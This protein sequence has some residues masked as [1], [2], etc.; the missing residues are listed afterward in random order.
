LKQT[1]I[2][3]TEFPLTPASLQ[4]QRH[5]PQCSRRSPGPRQLQ[6]TAPARPAS[7]SHHFRPHLAQRNRDVERDS[8]PPQR[9]V[10][11]RKRPGIRQQLDLQPHL[12][13]RSSD[14][15][16]A[17]RHQQAPRRQRRRLRSSPGRRLRQSPSSPTLLQALR[18][19]RGPRRPT[20]RLPGS[21]QNRQLPDNRI[22]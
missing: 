1:P 3:P 7:C 8:D 11:G 13:V 14:A 5:E 12:H 9:A 15:H 20:R 4:R 17:Q 16:V 10:H 18:R 22:T 19:L 21:V 2:D 6:W